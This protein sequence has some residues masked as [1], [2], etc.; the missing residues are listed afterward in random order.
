MKK[1]KRK[2]V[3]EALF[4][5]PKNDYTRVFLAGLNRLAENRFKPD[6]NVKRLQIIE[7]SGIS[8]RP[9][10]ALYVGSESLLLVAYYFYEVV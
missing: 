5:K 7:H 6:G 2:P 10:H 4:S 1:K 3:K 8:M 9:L